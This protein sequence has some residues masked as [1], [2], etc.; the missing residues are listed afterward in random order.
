MDNDS[1]T[2]SNLTSIVLTR[3]AGAWAGKVSET[4]YLCFYDP[5]TWPAAKRAAVKLPGGCA[6]GG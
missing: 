2:E 5:T 4:E 3:P 6:R 1:D